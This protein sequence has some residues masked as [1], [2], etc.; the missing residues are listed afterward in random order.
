M[1]IDHYLDF[2][3]AIWVPSEFAEYVRQLEDVFSCN[4]EFRTQA[5]TT[6]NTELMIFHSYDHMLYDD[7]YENLERIFTSKGIPYVLVETAQEHADQLIRGVM[8]NSYGES[9]GFY[10]WSDETYVNLFSVVEAYDAD[11]ETRNT[12]FQQLKKRIEGVMIPSWEN[13]VAYGKQY[14]VNKLTHHP[15]VT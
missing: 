9:M 12:F 3:Y 13:Q 5:H 7:S 2:T 4:C 1:N 10:F 8:F 6:D 11:E 14:L 15:G